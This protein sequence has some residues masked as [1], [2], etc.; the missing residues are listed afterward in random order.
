MLSGMGAVILMI[1]LGASIATAASFNC[2]PY[3]KAGTCPESAICTDNDLSRADSQMS[4][5]HASVL[6]GAARRDARTFVSATKPEGKQRIDKGGLTP[7][8][9][10][11]IRVEGRCMLPEDASGFC[12]PGYRH[13]DGKCVFGYKAPDPNGKLPSWQIEAIQ[14]GCPKGM[15]W[16]KSE[17]CHEND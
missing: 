6:K 14:K 10:G 5:L 11:Q 17:G 12:G 8:K 1:I 4:Q 7:C 15:A 9:K 16:N 13:D 2:K 3:V